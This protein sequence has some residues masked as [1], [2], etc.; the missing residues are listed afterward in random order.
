MT[1]CASV[2]AAI[3]YSDVWSTTD[4]SS[5]IRIISNAP[6]GKR[7]NYTS[8]AFNNKMWIVGGNVWNQSGQNDVWNSSDGIN[9]TQVASNTALTKG[10]IYKAAIFRGRIYLIGGADYRADSLVTMDVFESLDGVSWYKI[11]APSGLTNQ[12]HSVMVLDDKMVL[13]VNQRSEPVYY[14]VQATVTPTP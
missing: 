6:W 8:F 2:K 5:W 14:S 12:G 1:F 7:W 13:N 3:T 11:T 10:G 9:W 4:G